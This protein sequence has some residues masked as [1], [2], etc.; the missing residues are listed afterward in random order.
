[1][2]DTAKPGRVSFREWRVESLLSQ[3]A[4]GKMFGVG[5]P[6]VAHWE[7][8]GEQRPDI[9]TAFLVQGETKG[10]VTAASWGYSEEEIE[11]AHRAL[12]LAFNN[13]QAA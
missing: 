7:N 13:V 9:V 2:D 8:E 1:M 5:Q 11:R 3:G 4:A 10:R 6:A 12:T